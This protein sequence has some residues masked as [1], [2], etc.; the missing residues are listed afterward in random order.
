MT[1]KENRNIEEGKDMTLI[2]LIMTVMTQTD[3]KPTAITRII[4]N[5]C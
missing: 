5:E 3:I 1:R 4:A 2:T